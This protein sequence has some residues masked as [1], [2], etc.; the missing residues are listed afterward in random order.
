MAGQHLEQILRF[1][2]IYPG[3]RQHCSECHSLDEVATLGLSNGFKFS[4]IHVVRH[5]AEA[6]L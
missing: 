2:R 4:G 3:R 6:T 1:R 5:Q